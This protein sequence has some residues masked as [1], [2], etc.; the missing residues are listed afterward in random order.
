MFETSEKLRA[1]FKVPFHPN[2]I[3]ACSKLSTLPCLAYRGEFA[4]RNI[5]AVNAGSKLTTSAS[6]ATSLLG[7][8]LNSIICSATPGGVGKL[9][10]FFN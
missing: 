8:A 6:I 3:T 9:L 1:K 10:Q 7:C 4:K 5:L 2:N